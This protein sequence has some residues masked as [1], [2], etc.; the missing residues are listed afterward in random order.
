MAV[1]SLS[2]ELIKQAFPFLKK[3]YEFSCWSINGNLEKACYDNDSVLD[4]LPKYWES[5]TLDVFPDDFRIFFNMPYYENCWNCNRNIQ[6][7]WTKIVSLSTFSC[8]HLL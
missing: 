8:L 4:V 1:L 5:R 7:F 2:V 3:Y 6:C